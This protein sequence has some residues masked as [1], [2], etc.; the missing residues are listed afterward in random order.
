MNKA[1]YKYVGPHPQNKETIIDDNTALWLARMLW[2]EGGYKCSEKKCSCLL[3]AIM[4]RWNLW[5]G[6]KYYKTFVKLIRA[7]SQ[8]INPI[9]QKGGTM[10]E[11]YK[12]KPAGSIQRLKRR[13][14]VSTLTWKKLEKK[15]PQIVKAVK[16]F[17]KG[18]LFPADVLTTIPKARISNWASLPST[19]TKYP[20]G[21]DIDGDWFF[22]DES[23]IKGFV[24]VEIK[25]SIM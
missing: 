24:K 23:L 15:A 8:P 13:A 19:P 5:P 9:W 20:H 21:L 17:Q 16:E 3:W 4:N 18:T 1:I 11:K 14:F 10:A 2:G 22:E 6:R 12:N 25:E 7:F